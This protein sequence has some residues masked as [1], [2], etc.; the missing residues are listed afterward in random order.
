M[1]RSFLRRSLRAA[2][3]AGVLAAI[4][5]STPASA[6]SVFAIDTDNNLF[7]F[8]SAAPSAVL[9]AN[10]VTG[11]AQ[12]E[13]LVGIDFRPATGQL[14]ALGSGNNLYTLNTTTGAATLVGGGIG[15]TLSG[16]AFGFDFNPTVDR[17]RVVS[18]TDMNIRLNPNTGGLAATDTNLAFAGTD[19]NA[20]KNPSVVGSAYTNNFPGALTTTLYGIDS[21]LDV[22]VTQVPP[23]NGTLNTVGSL[24]TPGP[25]PYADATNL[26]GFDIFNVNTAY[27]ALQVDGGTSGFYTIDL[28][29]GAATL[30]GQIGGGLWVRDI[31]VSIVPEPSS[32]ALLAFGM[33]G[34]ARFGSRRAR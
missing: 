19:I 12:N 7:S 14:W 17:I 15:T 34:L 31:A 16:T 25:P 33:A 22:L 4:A 26:T 1:F 5:G 6:V 32:L 28:T 27:A 24:H 20:G 9:T 29:T 2:L 30:A 18:D 13:I 11:L 10:F 3:A 21:V 23:N 8:D